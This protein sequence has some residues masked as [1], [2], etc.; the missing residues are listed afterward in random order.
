MDAQRQSEKR[1]V[2]DFR[3]RLEVDGT[4]AIRPLID[5]GPPFTVGRIEFRGNHRFGDATLRRAIALEE[6]ALFDAERLRRSVA[7]LND[8]KLFEPLA[9]DDIELRR[10]DAA[11]VADI[12]F[13]MREKPRGRWALSGPVI[14]AEIAGPFSA[15]ITSRLPAWGSGLLEASTWYA[16]FNLIGLP[17]S[18]ARLIP[19]APRSGLLPLFSLERPLLP[20]QRWIS[21]FAISP[22][23]GWKSGLAGYGLGQAH[24]TFRSLL[25][26]DLLRPPALVAPVEWGSPVVRPARAGALICEP[27]KPRWSKVRTAAASLNEFL[28]G[29]RPF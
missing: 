17:R 16:S 29:V 9:G 5:E 20:G 1:G 8:L 24:Q 26:A 27:P 18:V 21:G 15:S 12:T 3:P 6:G 7:R 13:R 23:L 10:D 22:Q 19:F 25:H 14:P 2:M 4:L 28:L 11:H